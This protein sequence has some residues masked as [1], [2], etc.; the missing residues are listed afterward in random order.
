VTEDVERERT[1]KERTLLCFAARNIPKFSVQGLKE[2][3]KNIGQES[4]YYFSEIIARNLLP[5]EIMFCNL[6]LHVGRF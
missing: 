3:T 4:P 5:L 6:P 1:W 2:I